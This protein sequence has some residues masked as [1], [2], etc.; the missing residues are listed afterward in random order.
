MEL[1]KRTPEEQ[2][3]IDKDRSRPHAAVALFT[4]LSVLSDFQDPI[5]ELLERAT[6]QI[7]ERADAAKMIVLGTLMATNT[8][9][10]DGRV[11]LSVT[12]LCQWAEIEKLEEQQRRAFLAGGGGSPRRGA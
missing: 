4:P 11:Y 1:V 9:A 3:K 2:A 10:L 7:K 6:V 5:A 12:L 8:V